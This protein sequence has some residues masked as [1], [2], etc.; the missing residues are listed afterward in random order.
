MGRKWIE[1][2]V[3]RDREFETRAAAPEG[4]V[5]SHRGGVLTRAADR[6]AARGAKRCSH[7]YFISQKKQKDANL[8]RMTVN[9]AMI[10]TIT[11]IGIKKVFFYFISNIITD[12]ANICIA[13][14]TLFK[15]VTCRIPA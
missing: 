15:V 14:E 8:A 5:V 6:A 1:V 3:D 12:A 10:N 4:A 9:S 13:N 2:E 7:A 11:R